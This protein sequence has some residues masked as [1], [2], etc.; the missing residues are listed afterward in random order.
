MEIKK[1][2]NEIKETIEFMEK[3]RRKNNVVMSGLAIETYDQSV[4][5]DGM[6]NFIKHN[7]K[8]DVKIKNAYKLGEKTCLIELAEHEE[9]VKVMKNKSKLRHVEEGKVYI[10]DDTT[11]KEREIQKIIRKLAQE[12]KEKGNDVRH[13]GNKIWI[14]KVGWNW[15]NKENK[16]GKMEKKKLVNKCTG[17]TM[18]NEA[19]TMDTNNYRIGSKDKDRSSK[20]M[21][22][23]YYDKRGNDNGHEQ[24]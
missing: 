19:M 10:N 16:L 11:N 5:K 15:D 3:Q 24:L 20:Q 8:I 4:L 18:T 17:N 7:L 14:N 2:L 13:G 1:E 23:K 21:Y 12:E 9:K 6:S 22:R